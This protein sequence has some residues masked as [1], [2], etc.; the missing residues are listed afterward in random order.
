MRRLCWTV[1]YRGHRNC[2]SDS[3]SLE[4]SVSWIIQF[5]INVR[6]CPII[7]ACSFTWTARTCSFTSTGQNK[8]SSTP[9]KFPVL[10]R[11]RA[12]RTVQTMTVQNNVFW[13]LPKID[14]FIQVGK[15]E[16]I[17]QWGIHGHNKIADCELS[18]SYLLTHK[19]FSS[20]RFFTSFE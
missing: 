10:F 20:N 18:N 14:R 12:I 5:P 16:C 17:Y 7:R 8:I 19:T 6:Y 15:Y 4:S 9:F 13:K 11:P 1:S 3:F 2:W